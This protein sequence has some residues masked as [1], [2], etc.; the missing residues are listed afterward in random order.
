MK[1]LKQY[2]EKILPTTQQ[3]C[4]NTPATSA[5][6]GYFKVF[7]ACKF[8]EKSAKKWTIKKIVK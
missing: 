8:L 3:A 6:A 4:Q 5:I 7:V 2:V 1:P